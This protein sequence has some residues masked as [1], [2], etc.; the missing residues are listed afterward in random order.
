MVCEVHPAYARQRS[1]L[2]GLP[3][4]DLI[5]IV[6]GSGPVHECALALWCALGGGSHSLG[7]PRGETQLIFD[8]LCEAGWPHS[9]VEIARRGYRRTGELL[10]PLV[11]LLSREL[12][13]AAHEE[14]DPLPPE[15]MI[16]DTPGW[17]AKPSRG[18]GVHLEEPHQGGPALTSARSTTCDR[19]SRVNTWLAKRPASSGPWRS[20]TLV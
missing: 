3:T 1:E 14:A 4:R 13:D 5:A 20:S 12:T 18:R 8:H 17:A 15:V 6:C 10:S 19:R 16:G 11:A 7:Y 9:I 2:R